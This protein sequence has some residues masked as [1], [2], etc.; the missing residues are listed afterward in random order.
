MIM[1]AAM[2]RIIGRGA[3]LLLLLA[4]VVPGA[5]DDFGRTVI[6]PASIAAFAIA[7]LLGFTFTGLL[8]GRR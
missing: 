2:I 6:L 4:A 1:M 3:F 8:R 7:M 5:F